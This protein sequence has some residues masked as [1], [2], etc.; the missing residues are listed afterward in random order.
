MFNHHFFENCGKKRLKRFLTAGSHGVLLLTD[1]PFGGMVEAL[2]QS[3]I[4]ISQMWEETVASGSPEETGLNFFLFKCT[5]F[6]FFKNEITA[7]VSASLVFLLM[8]YRMTYFEM[9]VIE[10]YKD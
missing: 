8:K 2:S 9:K 7:I 6:S 1:P 3:F 10:I 5:C 4:K